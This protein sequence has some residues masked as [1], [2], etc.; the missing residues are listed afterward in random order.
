[1]AHL[2]I[3]TPDLNRT[4]QKLTTLGF[5]DVEMLPPGST[6]ATYHGH[7][8]QSS[9]KKAW[10]HGTVPEI[11]LMEAAAGTENPWSGELNE[12]G[13]V[14][15]HIAFAVPDEPAA[16]A[17]A[18]GVGMMPMA[19]GRWPLSATEWGTWDYVRDPSG[20]LIIEFLAK[21]SQK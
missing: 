14:I 4:V 5:T 19:G 20:A 9:L 15:H 10:I 18:A 3:L 6:S 8:I 1:M 13:E 12:K 11:E 7:T 16:L 17:A 21:T 2:G